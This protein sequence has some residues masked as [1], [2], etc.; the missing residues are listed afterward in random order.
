LENKKYVDD[1]KRAGQV[2]RLQDDGA[3]REALAEA[4]FGDSQQLLKQKLNNQSVLGAS[5][6]D[7]R[8]AL[9]QLDIDD[10]YDIFRT[11]QSGAGQ[12]ATAG[13]LGTVVT[14]GIGYASKKAE[15]DR[16]AAALAK[17]QKSQSLID[18]SQDARVPTNR[19]LG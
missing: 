18:N 4:T 16:E 15:Q 13:A 5:E 19:T 11:E 14:A 6:R 9:A 2:D 17:E 1:L 10:A 3:F 8:K 7:Y 12:R